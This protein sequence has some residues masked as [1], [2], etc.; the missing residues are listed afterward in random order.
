MCCT[1]YLL[2]NVIHPL[3]QSR[4]RPRWPRG[5][6][7]GYAAARLLGLRVRIPPGA[8]MCCAV[9]DKGTSQD[10]QEEE[11]SMEKV[12]REGKKLPPRIWMSVSCEW[13][14]YACGGL[15]PRPEESY[16]LWGVTVCDIE[17]SQNEATLP[18]VGLL[19]KKKK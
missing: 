11:T 2:S 7:R 8:W 4:Q 13:C 16:R 17:T 5:L 10:N 19:C 18:R 1:R 15:I 6:R 12:Q 14:M 9:K 3:N